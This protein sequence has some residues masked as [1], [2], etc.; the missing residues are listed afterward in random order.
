MTG[1]LYTVIDKN[2]DDLRFTPSTSGPV[3]FN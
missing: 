3:D 2:L 1:Y